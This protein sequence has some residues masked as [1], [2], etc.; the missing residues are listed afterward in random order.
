[1]TVSLST[2]RLRQVSELYENEY[3]ESL[4]RALDGKCGTKL[5]LCLTAM[6]FPV[7]DFLAAR[8]MKAMKGCALLSIAQA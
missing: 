2:F 1:M 6:L 7:R 3:D 4:S 5:H 8:L